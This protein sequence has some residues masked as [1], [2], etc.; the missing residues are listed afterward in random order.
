MEFENVRVYGSDP[1]DG[2]ANASYSNLC[3]LQKPES[4]E[5]TVSTVST[6]LTEGTSIPVHSFIMDPLYDYSLLWG[7]ANNFYKIQNMVF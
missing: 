3:I 4:A 7:F 5:S 6:E 1:F 2:A